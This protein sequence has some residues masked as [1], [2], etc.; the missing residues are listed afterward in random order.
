MKPTL[1]PI[2]FSAVVS[3]I[4]TGIGCLGQLWLVYRVAGADCGIEMAFSIAC[5]VA[6][7]IGCHLFWIDYRPGKEK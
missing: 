6:V 7:V 5:L 1:K 3:F 4:V 2:I